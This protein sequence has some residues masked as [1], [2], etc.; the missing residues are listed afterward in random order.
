[1]QCQVSIGIPVDNLIL[2]LSLYSVEIRE[3]Q[4]IRTEE[5]DATD[6]IQSYNDEFIF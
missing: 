2:C 1:M 4:N 6:N 5:S 3:I